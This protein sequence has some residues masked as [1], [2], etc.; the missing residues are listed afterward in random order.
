MGLWDYEIV[1]LLNKNMQTFLISP[2]FS[3]TAKCLDDKR[4]WKQ[5]LEANSLIKLIK[6]EKTTKHPIFRMW[7]DHVLSLIFYRDVILNEWLE[8]R[9]VNKPYI[10]LGM[11][12][13]L[14]FWLNDE[15]LY[16]SHR[17]NLLRKNPKWYGQ[18]GWVETKDEKY[19]WPEPK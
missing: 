3:D 12:E 4:L 10:S 7:S 19:Y 1:T 13:N 9:L 15:K 6:E 16:S 17:S 11:P 8:R 2:I 18:F 14:P 5:V